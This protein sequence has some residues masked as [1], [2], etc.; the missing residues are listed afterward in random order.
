[1][2]VPAIREVLALR[3]ADE[4][5]QLS[6]RELKAQKVVPPRR[7]AEESWRIPSRPYREWRSVQCFLRCCG[8]GVWILLGFFS[9]A[10][11]AHA[12]DVGRDGALESAP[13][14]AKSLIWR[15][16]AHHTDAYNEWI[17]SNPSPP[18][19]FSFDGVS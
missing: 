18:P 8:G 14:F 10:W 5:G 9:V 13:E 1:M 12:W 11:I 15:S 7:P 3:T 2:E 16:L 4:S 19:T 17:G 6:P